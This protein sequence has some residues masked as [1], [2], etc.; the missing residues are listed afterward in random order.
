[1]IAL[2]L[3]N[4]NPR[5]PKGEGS[6]SAQNQNESDLRHLSNLNYILFGHFDEKKLRVTPSGWV[7]VSRQRWWVTG[8]VVATLPP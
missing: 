5:L 3:S 2:L 4:V 8:V 6:L 1:M 7:K